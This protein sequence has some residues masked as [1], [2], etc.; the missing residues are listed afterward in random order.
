[1]PQGRHFFVIHA[2][3][4]VATLVFKQKKQFRFFFFFYGKLNA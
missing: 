3:Y 2:P 4:A 1:M